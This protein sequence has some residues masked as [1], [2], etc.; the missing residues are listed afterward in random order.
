MAE[1]IIGPTSDGERARLGVVVVAQL[2]IITESVRFAC[3]TAPP[4]KIEVGQ[5]ERSPSGGREL[6]VPA[7][8]GM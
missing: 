7:R 4:G 2:R 3:V 8:R 5:T 1:A 6:V